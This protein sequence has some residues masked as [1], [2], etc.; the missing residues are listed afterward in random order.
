[1]LSPK[2]LKSVE[3]Q[4]GVDQPQPREGSSLSEDDTPLAVRVNSQGPSRLNNAGKQRLR[5]VKTKIA[6]FV[7]PRKKKEANGIHAFRVV[8]Y[9]CDCNY[10][11]SRAR[12]KYT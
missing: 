4:I 11:C 12:Y 2:A 6:G 5:P 1:M 3:G 9:F 10:A 8:I 7:I